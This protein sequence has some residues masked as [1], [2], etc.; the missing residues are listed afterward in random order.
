MLYADPSVVALLN[1]GAD[2]F[3]GAKCYT[4]TLNNGTVLLYTGADITVTLGGNVFAVGPLID[5][6]KRSVK[7]GLTVDEQEITVAPRPVDLVL[8]QPMIEAFAAGLFDNAHLQLDYAWMTAFGTPAVGQMA[9]LFYGRVS[10]I[11]KLGRMQAQLKV[12]SELVGMDRDFPHRTYQAQCE[13]QLYGYGC[14]LSK[15]AFTHTMTVA[16]G[17]TTTAI[18]LSGSVTDG[19]PYSQG[20]ILFTSGTLAGVTATIR[21]SSNAPVTLILSAPLPSAPHAGD[22]CSISW[23]CNHTLS[24][25]GGCGQFA[26][27]ARYPG[28]PYVPAPSTGL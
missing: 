14:F 27:T 13:Y 17:T 16:A 21:G 23:G 7:R 8:G 25:A 3:V 9:P 1:S 6:L 28:F 26:N 10:T 19:T 11:E 5:G 12:K 18:V 15:A 20:T 24:S 4:F 22:A 2:R